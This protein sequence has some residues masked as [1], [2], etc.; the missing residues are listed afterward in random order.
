MN[1]AIH[2]M[3]NSHIFL[4]TE[5]VWYPFHCV[6]HRFSDMTLQRV[7]LISLYTYIHNHSLI[8]V[9]LRVKAYYITF[10]EHVQLSSLLFLAIHL[11]SDHVI[12][13]FLRINSMLPFHL[14]ILP[15]PYLILSVSHRGTSLV[16]CLTF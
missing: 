1:L 4:K 16:C 13:L 14:F 11:A 7:C 5:Y 9:C 10:L 3:F 15:E 8:Y 2:E 12:S 6:S